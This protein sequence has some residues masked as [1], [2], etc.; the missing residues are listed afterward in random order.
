LDDPFG[1][2]DDEVEDED[3]DED[4]TYERFY[5][6]V[7]RKAKEAYAQIGSLSKLESLSLSDG[8][9][10]DGPNPRLSH[11]NDLTLQG[12]LRQLAGLKKLKYFHMATDFW[13]CMD[14]AEG[15]TMA[16]TGNSRIQ[17]RELEIHR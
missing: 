5:S 17:L 16:K 3:E 12:W 1:S 2:N 9:V 4:R 8:T 7:E 11:N 10:V 13:S 14:Q 15:C 6:W